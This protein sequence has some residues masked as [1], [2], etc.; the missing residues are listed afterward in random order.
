MFRIGASESDDSSIVSIGGVI[1]SCWIHT[2]DT[3]RSFF[4]ASTYTIFGSEF[5][6]SKDYVV[7]ICNEDVNVDYVKRVCFCFS[8][9]SGRIGGSRFFSKTNWIDF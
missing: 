2:S 7:Y 4:F 1:F 9:L 8:E 6:S 3:K 5:D